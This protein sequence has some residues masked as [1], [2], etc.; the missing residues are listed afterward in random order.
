VLFYEDLVQDPLGV[1]G[2]WSGA[3][4]FGDTLSEPAV[5]ESLRAIARPDLNH[6]P[7]E[8]PDPDGLDKAYEILRRDA[9]SPEETVTSLRGLLQPVLARTVPRPS[10]EMQLV[11]A[12]KPKVA[13]L[14]KANQ[15]LEARLSAALE[16][17]ARL[18]IRLQHP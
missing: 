7:T 14:E 6:A 2:R 8:F 5:V 10:L 15:D 13:A 3:L 18:L 12:L 9:A 11:A 1:L 4:E 17:N 16:E